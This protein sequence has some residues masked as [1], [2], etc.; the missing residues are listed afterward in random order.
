MVSVLFG[1]IFAA[2][3]TYKGYQIVNFE[4]KIDE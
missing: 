4:V 2:Y 3:E 1:V